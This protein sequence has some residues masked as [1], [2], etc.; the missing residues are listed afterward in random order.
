MLIAYIYNVKKKEKLNTEID[1]ILNYHVTKEDLNRFNKI[2]YE[3]ITFE[4]FILESIEATYR[5]DKTN[6]ILT[7]LKRN[8]RLFV[9]DSNMYIANDAIDYEV[10]RLCKIAKKAGFEYIL[11]NQYLN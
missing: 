4:K 7:V 5:I 2:V 9:D 3:E 8:Y 1:A 6:K 10:I 11:E